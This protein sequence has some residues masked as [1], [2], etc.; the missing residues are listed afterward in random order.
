MELHHGQVVDLGRV[1]LGR[2]SAEPGDIG[3]TFKPHEDGVLV[4]WVMEAGPAEAAGLRVGDRVKSIDGVPVR[5]V[6][7]A[8]ARVL[9]APGS[10]LRLGIRDWDGES[11]EEQ[12]LPRQRQQH[13]PD[14]PSER[15]EVRRPHC[16]LLSQA[17]GRR[18]PPPNATGPWA[19]LS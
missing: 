10:N 15:P 16:R 11:L 9:G 17:E 1:A 8:E 6:A 2:M 13:T 18:E 3:A 19:L 4:V 7:D 5:E 12:S 14:R